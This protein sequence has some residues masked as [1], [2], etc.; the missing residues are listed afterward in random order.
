MGVALMTPLLGACATAT[1]PPD[2]QILTQAR[3]EVVRKRAELIRAKSHAR[4]AIDVAERT[5]GLKDPTPGAAMRAEIAAR[6]DALKALLRSDKT[7]DLMSATAELEGRVMLVSGVIGRLAR[8]EEMLGP[9]AKDLSPA[10]L[11]PVTEVIRASKA[12]LTS[13]GWDDLR[14]GQ[15][16]LAQMDGRLLVEAKMCWEI[17]GQVDKLGSKVGPTLRQQV[18][19]ALQPWTQALRGEDWDEV[20]ALCR[21]LP[22]FVGAPRRIVADIEAGR[23]YLRFLQPAEQVWL[24]NEF[25]AV[26]RSLQ[27]SS[28]E[29]AASASRTALLA[30]YRRFGGGEP[31][32]WAPCVRILSIDGGGVRGLIPAMLLERLELLTQQ[33]IHRLFDYVVG[34]SAGGIIALGLTVPDPKD[35]SK[36]RYRATDLV[37]LFEKDAAKIF[38]ANP[39]KAVRVIGSPRYSPKGLEDVLS[40]YFGNTLV[41]DA[42]TNVLVTTYN[43]EERQGWFM[44]NHDYTAALYMREAARATSAAPT[45]FPPAQLAIPE[46]PLKQGAGPPIPSAEKINHISLLDGG[47]FANNP[48]AHG[49]IRIRLDEDRA[50]TGRT[51]S[52]RPWLL[53]SLGTGQLP[54]SVPSSDPRGWGLLSW[55]NPLVDIMFSN[56]GVDV[57]EVKGL[58]D[59]YYRLQ[60]LT[61]TKDTAR[62]DGSDPANVAAL[63]EIA[64]KFVQSQ[65]GLLERIARLLERERP[66]EC[67]RE[68]ASIGV[69]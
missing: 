1:K 29:D 63:K 3:Q 8:V 42:L 50:Q 17:K 44:T 62:L 49:L 28:W 41:A 53:L 21:Q 10:L 24:Q 51:G 26:D 14:R 58:G 39:L 4:F 18:D 69:R 12:A 7:A 60:P 15:D 13:G 30:V 9:M 47:V 46:R 45:Y 38:P 22:A 11:A 43:L 27:G 23:S 57:R 68:P 48:A 19:A 40:R 33:P 2:I 16:A 34:T 59:Y 64:S 67:Q 36:A 65:E 37:D 32:G 35:A 66:A 6:S 25:R 56:A 52:E 55:A 5:G 54:S 61:L 31:F 20:L